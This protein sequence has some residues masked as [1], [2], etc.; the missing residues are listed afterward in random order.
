M[1]ATAVICLITYAK[2][3]EIVR[4]ICD[5]EFGCRDL[6]IE[7]FKAIASVLGRTSPSKSLILN[8]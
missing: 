1:D 7:D 5:Q 8:Q 6:D 2:A 4:E 3:E